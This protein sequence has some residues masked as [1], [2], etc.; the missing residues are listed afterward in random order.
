MKKIL[1]LIIIC[2][3][4]IYTYFDYKSMINTQTEKSKIIQVLP[5]DNIIKTLSREFGY[6]EL[7]LKIYT[8]LNKEKTNFNLEKWEYNIQN[9]LDLEWIIKNLK[10]WAIT[11]EKNLTILPW[12]NI[13]DIDNYLTN[14]NIIKKW[15]FISYTKNIDLLKKEYSFLKDTLTLEWYLYPDTYNINPSNF[16]INKFVNDILKNTQK[17]LKENNLDNYSDLQKTINIASIV[18]KEEKNPQE[19]SKVAWVLIKRLNENWMLWADA[20]A[21]YAYKLTQ[22]DCKMNL[23]KYIYEKNEYNTRTKVWLPLTPISN[24]SIETIL[25]VKNYTNSPYYYYLH[26]TTTWQIYYAKTLEEHNVNKNK[27][28]K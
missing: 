13:Y 27:Y 14:I 15:E 5:W 28:I 8:K 3:I 6:N 17:K 11:I 9:W 7:Y 19:K 16:T 22:E 26:D 12:W 24:P 10:W 2:I 25:S 23:S 4:P 18:E 1:L 21:C 20:T